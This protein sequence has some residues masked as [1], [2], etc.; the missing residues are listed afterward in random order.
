MI[1]NDQNPLLGKEKMILNI[2]S[3]KMECKGDKR[4]VCII[5]E[6]LYE[7]SCQKF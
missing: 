6:S 4:E 7:E 5:Q 2:I 1:E 3:K